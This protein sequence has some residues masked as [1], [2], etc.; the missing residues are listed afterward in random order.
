MIRGLLILLLFTSSLIQAGEVYRWVDDK[1]GVHY[2]D[3]PPPSSAKQ[4]IK[5]K[6][7][8]NVVD[9]D[10]ESFE[11]RLAREKHPVVLYSTACGPICDQARDY[12]TQRGIPFLTKDPAKDQEIASE[13][14]KLVGA[15]EVPVILVG[16]LHEKGFDPGSWDRL[17][18]TAGYPKTPLIPVKTSTSKQP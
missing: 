16:K 8:G 18:D 2:S 4:S 10:K 3:Q 11:G 6:S 1:G 17:L 12:L 14:K 15:V 9:V 5:V 7:R 13:V